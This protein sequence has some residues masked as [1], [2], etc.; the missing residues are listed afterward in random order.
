VKTLVRGAAEHGMILGTQFT[1]FTSTTV[2][3]L[4]QTSETTLL[5][6]ALPATQAVRQYFVLLY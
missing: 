1:C 2:Q 4:T 6:P 3:M 5:G